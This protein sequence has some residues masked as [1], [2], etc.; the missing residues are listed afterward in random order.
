M[1]IVTGSTG[2][3]GNVLIR[4]LISKGEIVRAFICPG[5]NLEPIKDLPVEK[6][7]GDITDIESIKLAFEGV[8]IVYHL[9]GIISTKPGM[10]KI[11]EKVNV[12]GTKNVI[13]AC[14]INGIKKLVYVS[15]IHALKDQKKGIINEKTEINPIK[16]IGDYGFS[17]AKATLEVFKAVKQGLNAVVVCPTGIIGPYDY[18]PSQM[19]NLILSIINGKF[20][21][22]LTG[23]YDFVDVRDV[24]EGIILAAKK[25]KTGQHYV[26]S[27]N[28]IKI[29]DLIDKV[30]L[31]VGKNPPKIT[32]N[33]K[34]MYVYALFNIIGS[35][36]TKKTPLVTFES[37]Y[38]L[39]SNS[40]ISNKLAKNELNYN[41]RPL[42]ITLK[43]TVKWFN[44]N[45]RLFQNLSLMRF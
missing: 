14:K 29:S 7:Y 9:A 11:L 1:V 40:N 16:A 26:L 28:R 12:V 21:V 8:D 18:K 24:A 6:I 44:D 27:G 31:L 33:S 36:F 4:K 39:N 2:H 22:K 13:K 23:A 38:I 10:K 30:S 41:P 20:P 45:N 37:I 3:L 17:K 35:F 42:D 34:L 43:D 5:E 25:G 15:S 19:G 32:I